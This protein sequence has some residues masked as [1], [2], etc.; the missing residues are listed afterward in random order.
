M[1]QEEKRL[2]D[3]LNGYTDAQYARIEKGEDLTKEAPNKMKTYA[4]YK[5][6]GENFA[7]DM[8]ITRMND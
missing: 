2:R 7:P 6:K 1:N 4:A 3:H 5:S 8:A